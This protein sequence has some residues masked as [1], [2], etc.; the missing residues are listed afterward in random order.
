[1]AWKSEFEES[2]EH[3]IFHNVISDDENMLIAEVYGFEKL[4]ERTSLILAA[5]DLLDAC[6]MALEKMTAHGMLLSDNFLQ[7][8]INKARGK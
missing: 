4:D 7:R 2:N 8:A 5:P 1:M 3:R 6:E